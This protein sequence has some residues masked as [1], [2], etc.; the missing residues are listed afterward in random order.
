MPT[1]RKMGVKYSKDAGEYK[2][3]KKKNTPHLIPFLFLNQLTNVLL[4][5]EIKN[6]A[7]DPIN[8][9]AAEGKNHLSGLYEISNVI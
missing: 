4:L 3:Y 2:G 7:I 5:V 6:A 1:A 9:G 8:I